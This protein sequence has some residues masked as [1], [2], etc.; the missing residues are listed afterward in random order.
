M[1]IGRVKKLI[2]NRVAL[3]GNIDCSHLLPFGTPDDVKKATIECIRAASPGGGHIISSSNTI[4]DSVPAENFVAMVEA[5]REY[6]NYPI[7]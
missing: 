5:A 3:W 4:H 7:I 6:G 2:G 1:D